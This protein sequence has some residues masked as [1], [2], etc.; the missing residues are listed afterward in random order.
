[1]CSL[2]RR[3]LLGALLLGPTAAKAAGASVVR[4]AGADV[5]A[6]GLVV[7]LSHSDL[8]DALSLD[9]EATLEQIEFERRQIRSRFLVSVEDIHG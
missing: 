3:S 6:E 7:A 1:M 2:S 9:F 4:V 5:Q 8:L